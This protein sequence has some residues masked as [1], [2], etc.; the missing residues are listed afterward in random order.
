MARQ[1]RWLLPNID[2]SAVETLGHALGIGMP[3]ASVLYGRG[4]RDAAS[5]RRFLCPSLDDLHDPM[6]MRGMDCALERLTRAIRNREKILIYGDYDVDGATSVVILKRSIELA[7]GLA[8]FHV[9]DRLKEGY[10][11]RPE[12]VET[13]SARGVS[14]IISVDT[15]IRAA[16]VVRRAHELSIDVIITDHHL[17]DAELPPAL[18]VLNPNRPDCDYPEKNLCGV[19]VA[20]K[21][22]QALVATLDWPPDKRRRILESFLKLVAIGTV[23]DVV[24][25]TGENRIIV[26]HGLSGLRDV[27]SPG[28]RALLEVAGFAKGSVPSATQ[29]AFR[30]APRMNA[31]GRM[32]TANDVIEMLLTSDAERAQILAEQ[33]HALNTERQKTEA[34]IIETILSECA[35]TPIDDSQPALVF[36]AP[37]WHRG[38][39]GIVASRLVERFHRPA[40]VLSEDRETGLAQG[41]GRSI[42]RF[43]LLEALESM[44]ELFEKFGGHSHAAGLTLVASKVTM[45]RRR[46]QDHAALRLTPE[47]FAPELEIDAVMTLREINERTVGEISALAPFGCG[48]PA[49]LFAA[50]SAEVAGPPVIWKEKHLRVPLRQEGR[51]LWLKAWNFAERVSEL[52]PGTLVDAALSLEEDSYG[53]ANGMPGWS[54]VLRD[55][56][57]AEARV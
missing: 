7:G 27:R 31:A 35:R 55:F 57:P 23:A 40:F 18:A 8:D 10:G 3:A 5:A 22:V 56:R 16:E 21:L 51:M 36:C 42:T 14:L 41:S 50:L 11:M 34:E 37:D 44:P 12:V 26:K 4:F 46:L 32:A 47:D 17:P 38:V 43:H 28:L 6:A 25:L 45:F 53:A 48:H 19:G 49:P 33:L 13:A 24:P 1:A 52:L 54:A 39:L 15:G 29:V 20:F 30:I 2:R 9:P